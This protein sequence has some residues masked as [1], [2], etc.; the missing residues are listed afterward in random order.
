[1][2]DEQKW[3]ENYSPSS[4]QVPSPGV[5]LLSVFVAR[6]ATDA[7]K[8]LIN[9]TTK[10]TIITSVMISIFTGFLL[11]G[12]AAAT[13]THSL[14]KSPIDQFDRSNRMPISNVT[15]NTSLTIDYF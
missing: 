15:E 10:G 1:M 2:T 14:V 3:I 5:R 11:E 7:K 9:R 12:A 13:T 8:S 4:K 6:C